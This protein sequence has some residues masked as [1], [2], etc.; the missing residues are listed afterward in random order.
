MGEG[1]KR[2]VSFDA[3]KITSAVTQ[4]ATWEEKRDRLKDGGDGAK[5]LE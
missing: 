2:G 5:N 4:S 3:E 1:K